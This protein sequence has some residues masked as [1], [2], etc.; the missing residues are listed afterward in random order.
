MATDRL[1]TA[2]RNFQHVNQMVERYTRLCRAY[3][4]LSERFH[5]LD[6]DHM[7]LKGQVVPLLKA[8]KDHQA[9]LKAIETEKAEIQARLDQQTA[10]HRQ[11][12]QQLTKTY[13]ERL[14]TLSNHIDE[15]QPLEQL[16]NGETNHELSIAEEQM[17]LVET[18]FLEIEQD[19]SPDLSIEEKALL[20]AY[21]ADPNAFLVAAADTPAGTNLVGTPVEAEEPVASLWNYY[22][23]DQVPDGLGR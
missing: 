7:T 18:T 19:S 20:A 1:E 3:V 2:V 10:Q 13:E 14:Q 12:L 21:Q 4:S 22:Y 23:D 6:V 8:L 16:L 9:K 17:E 15:L 5:Q 11:E